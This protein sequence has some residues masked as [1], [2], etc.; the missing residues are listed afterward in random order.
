MANFKLQ[1]I[2]KR[3]EITYLANYCY[4]LVEFSVISNAQNGDQDQSL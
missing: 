4:F 3:F 1:V 2:Q